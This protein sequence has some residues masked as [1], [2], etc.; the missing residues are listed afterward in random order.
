MALVVVSFVRE[1]L[2]TGGIS[3]QNPLSGNEIFSFS[4]IPSEFTLSLFTQPA[5]A[6]I[7]LALVAAIFA[8]LGKQDAE[9][10]GK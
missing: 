2:G 1:L 10:G 4:L 7:V 9:L 5:G 3:L 6:L 8:A